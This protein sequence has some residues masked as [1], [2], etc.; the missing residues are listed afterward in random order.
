MKK[1]KSSKSQYFPTVHLCR[2]ELDAIYDIL[3]EI[4]DDVSISDK[5]YSYES[6]DEL[7]KERG[8]KIGTLKLSSYSPHV[9]LEFRRSNAFN[10][11]FL[12]AGGSDEKQIYAYNEISEI[13]N[14]SRSILSYVLVPAIGYYIPW[15]FFIFSSALIEPLN[16][17]LGN[18]T[19]VISFAIL[20][21]A[22]PISTYLVRDG[23]LF[24]LNLEKRHEVGTFLS[25]QKD[26]LAKIIVGGL[27][28]ALITYLISK[29][30]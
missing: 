8:S 15:A 26:D 1:I 21:L 17:I 14:N 20:M 19:S 13:L 30:A 29:F 24:T 10:S 7:K 28:G 2:E 4:S 12:Y 27:F 6:L 5:N 9:T 18:K 22:L 11:I 25:R 23:K 3:S 16:N